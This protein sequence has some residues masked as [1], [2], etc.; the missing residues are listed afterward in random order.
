[1]DGGR[2]RRLCGQASPVV[3]VQDDRF[4]AIASVTICAFT[5]DPTDAPFFRPLVEPNGANGLLESSRLMAD[6]ITTMSRSKLG[7]RI[8]MLDHADIVRLDRAM[9]TFLGLIG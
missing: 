4:D 9:L 5:A 6:K 2:W 7:R 3:I 8:G 1:M